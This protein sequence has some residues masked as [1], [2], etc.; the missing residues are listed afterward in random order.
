MKIVHIITCLDDGGAEA[1]LFRLIQSL[2]H[3]IHIVVSLSGLGKYG[4]MLR[5]IGTEVIDL[6]MT[7]F[8]RKFSAFFRLAGLIRSI[9]PD[10]IQTW[11]YHADFV[12]GV[13][14]RMTG[15]RNIAWGLHN[16]MVAASDNSLPR[17]ALIRLNALLSHV[18]PEW[19]V[20]CSQAALLAHQGIGYSSRKLVF[21]PNGYPVDTF[22]PDRKTRM[23]TRAEFGVVD[24][25]VLL[26]MVA[27]FDPQKDHLNLLNALAILKQSKSFKCLLVGKGLDQ[28]SQLRPEIL[29]R[30]LCDYVLLVGQRGDISNVMNALDIFCLSSAFSEAFPNVLCEAMACCTPCV[31]TDVGDSALIVGDTGWVV[32]PRSPERLAAALVNAI[33]DLPDPGR[34]GAARRRIV[35]NFTVEKMSEAYRS[36]W[37]KGKNDQA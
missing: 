16:S 14:A 1:V 20:S 34:Q 5:R 30:G 13:A 21:I 19:V 11:M 22:R 32:P 36:I 23:Q 3:D 37:S 35:E 33:M 24:G 9:S 8:T 15:F 7:T 18:I 25:E 17:F 28:D 6:D 12:G 31:T 27:R 26:G 10:A 4:D 2:P 29:S